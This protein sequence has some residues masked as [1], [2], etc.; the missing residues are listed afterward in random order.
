MSQGNPTD[1]EID[2]YAQAIVLD[3][4]SKSDAWRKSYPTSKAKP[5]VVNLKAFHMHK[6]TKVQ[7]RIKEL[8]NQAK[9]QAEEKFNISVEWKMG[10]LKKAAELGLSSKIDQGGSEVPI[11]ISGTVAAIRELN[12]MSG[13]HA[14]FKH[15]ITTDDDVKPQPINIIHKVED[16]RIT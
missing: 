5:E 11:S 15:K 2:V 9:Q 8:Q 14:E 12:L 4:L 16:G 1:K 7:L 3:G 6:M 13:D 10:M